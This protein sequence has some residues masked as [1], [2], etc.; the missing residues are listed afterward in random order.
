M[1]AE[2]SKNK[3]ANLAKNGTLIRFIRIHSK[4]H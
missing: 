2:N 1:Y 4:E 3:L